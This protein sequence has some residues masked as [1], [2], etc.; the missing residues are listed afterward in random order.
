[1]HS[2]NEFG[3]LFS[4]KL[5][6]ILDPSELHRPE[7]VAF[8][9]KDLDKFRDYTVNDNDPISLRVLN[10]YKQMH[11]NQTVDFVRGKYFEMSW[12]MVN[13]WVGSCW[14][15]NHWRL[16][17]ISAKSHKTSAADNWWLP[18]YRSVRV[19]T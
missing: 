7:G 9:E 1:M 5:V 4:Q 6:N 15:G 17:E 16:A 3:P 19:S 13:L 14:N 12:A 10:T 18:N 8:A 11:K 2:S